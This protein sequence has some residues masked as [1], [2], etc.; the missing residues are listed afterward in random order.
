MLY[1]YKLTSA[2]PTY[3]KTLQSNFYN[4]LTHI[5]LSAL[6]KW[7]A[8]NFRL[9]IHIQT[10]LYLIVLLGCARLHCCIFFFAK[11]P[12]PSNR[13]DPILVRMQPICFCVSFHQILAIFTTIIGRKKHFLNRYLRFFQNYAQEKTFLPKI[14]P[15]TF[16][17]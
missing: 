4:N 12:T 8:R 17:F 1:A 9:Q 14:Y 3:L 15:K 11:I 6:Y 13:D 10:R 16:E 7:T 5:G 2:N